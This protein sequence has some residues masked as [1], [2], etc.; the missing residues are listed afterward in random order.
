MWIA[1]KAKG[2][3]TLTDIAKKHKLKSDRVLTLFHKNKWAKGYVGTKKPL[4]KGANL[5]VPDPRAKVYVTKFNGRDV[6]L[7]ANDKKASEAAL[8]R[9]MDSAYKTLQTALERA[10]ERHDFQEKVNK[11]FGWVSLICSITASRNPD[12][13]WYKA[14]AELKTLDLVVRSRTFEDFET[15]VKTTEKAINV[16][17]KA[18]AAWLKSLTG[19]AENWTTALTITK[20]ISFTVFSAA[21]MTA[22]APA[23]VGATLVYGAG[24]G[25]SSAFL[26]TTAKQ[27]GK[28]WA[29][30]KV[31]FK[32]AASDVAWNMFK[33]AGFG[34]AGAGASK[35]VCNLVAGKIAE[36]IGQSG[37]VQRLATK[38]ITGSD[39][40][41]KIGT[42]AV[43]K[44]IQEM[45][46]NGK[47]PGAAALHIKLFMT[48]QRVADIS[49][50]MTVAFVLR[51][52]TGR[53]TK[54]VLSAI[55]G[56]QDPVV[57]YLKRNL[58]SLKGNID[59][60]ALG[61]KVAD[62]LIASGKMD[63]AFA[64]IV[65]QNKSKIQTLIEDE[66]Q[67][68][69]EAWAAKNVKAAA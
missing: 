32:G 68:Q 26:S 56:S 39:L 37:M 9:V 51:A 57:D 6:V 29:G 22:A 47:L 40:S 8:G 16:Y 54:A 17:R 10:G 27:A 25:A 1:Y 42:R 5:W 65:D 43:R 20:D 61:A 7:D 34:A 48:P 45:I 41:S 31:T 44:G 62:S 64:A 50:K 4:N 35:L 19:S 46:K 15:Q 66:I 14:E 2:N 11:E 12:P 52:G 28:R 38:F 33:G 24:V 23:S 59:H 21:A 53:T 63:T 58:K 36:K 69:L 49:T 18:L 67:S 3:E 60:K 30:D 55:T 13:E